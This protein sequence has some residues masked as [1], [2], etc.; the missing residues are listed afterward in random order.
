MGDWKEGNLQGYLANSEL[1]KGKAW[2]LINNM[3]AKVK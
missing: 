3:V 2:E 1:K